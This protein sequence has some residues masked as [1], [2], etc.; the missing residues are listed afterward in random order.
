MRTGVYIVPTNRWYIER[1]VWLIAGIILLIAT[2]LAFL[3]HP[4]FALLVAVLGA[5]SVTVALTGFCVVGNLL[6]AVG[7]TPALG[8]PGP[9]PHNLY[10]MQTDR[11]YLERRIYLVVGINL[12]IATV[13]S[14][15]H[16]MWWLAFPAFVGVAMVWF[17]ATGFCIM[18]NGLYWLGA[19]P[20]LVPDACDTHPVTPLGDRPISA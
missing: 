9:T 14:L 18:A 17:A 8:R 4:L 6:K 16:T 1:T 7:F 20:R 3:A 5:F 19:E 12:N 10:F 13:L 2:A 11:W 15:T